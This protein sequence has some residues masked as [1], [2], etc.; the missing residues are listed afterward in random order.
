MTKSNERPKRHHYVPQFYLKKFLYNNQS[1]LFVLRK[2]TETS[3]SLIEKSPKATCY[4]EDLHTLSDNHINKK[5]DGIETFYS[6]IE[7][8][9]SEV[10]SEILKNDKEI[11][12]EIPIKLTDFQFFIKLFISFMFWRNPKYKSLVND[13]IIN[14]LELYNTSHHE[15]KSLINH[16]KKFIRYL[17]TKYHEKPKQRD[18]IL[19]FFQFIFFPIFGFHIYGNNKIMIKKIKSGSYISNDNPILTLGNFEE[20]KNFQK[21]IFPLTPNILIFSEDIVIENY[22]VKQI[23][24]MIA[25]NATKFIYGDPD[26]LKELKVFLEPDNDNQ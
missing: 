2:D 24:E 20:T 13:N 26:I 12:E 7:T 4:L 18:L 17:L 6:Q 16:D 22:S 15:Q 14:C 19:K 5:F 1:L 8:Q 25:K 23:N 10:I 9:Y 11:I 21:I 3:F